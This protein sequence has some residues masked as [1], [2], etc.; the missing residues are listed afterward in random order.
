ML[1]TN[2][3]VSGGQYHYLYKSLQGNGNPSPGLNTKSLQLQ[4]EVN[5]QKQRESI[6]N[7]PSA[8]GGLLPILFT[9]GVSAS[10]FNHTMW[11]HRVV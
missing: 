6:V 4:P 3:K 11:E 7:V 10:I 9:V 1:R 2:W 5:C 8:A